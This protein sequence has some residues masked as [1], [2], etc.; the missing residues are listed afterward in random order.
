MWI[1]LWTLQEEVLLATS[2]VEEKKMDVAAF[3]VAPVTEQGAT[4]Y[5]SDTGSDGATS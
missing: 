4:Q 3:L 5:G 2:D 1:Y